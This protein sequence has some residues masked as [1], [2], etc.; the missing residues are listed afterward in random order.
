MVRFLKIFVAVLCIVCILVLCIAPFADIP[1]TVLKALQ[2]VAMLMFG[3][4]GSVLLSAGIF[5]SA[6]AQKRVSRAEHKSPT[7]CP[8]LPLESNCVQ[9]C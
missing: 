4:M 2:I 5:R 9:R 3:L 8:L 7:R 1:V 6:P